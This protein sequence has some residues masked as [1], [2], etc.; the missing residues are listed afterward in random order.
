MYPSATYLYE[1][2]FVVFQEDR[3]P[4]KVCT[5]LL[6]HN[7]HQCHVL[8]QFI[9]NKKWQDTIFPSFFQGI[10]CVILRKSCSI[11]ISIFKGYD[12]PK[13]E[14]LCSTL[15]FGHMN[16]LCSLYQCCLIMAGA[17]FSKLFFYLSL[18]S[19]KRRKLF[20]MMKTNLIGKFSGHAQHI[21][22]LKMVIIIMKLII[23]NNTDRMSGIH[24]LQ[25]ALSYYTKN[26]AL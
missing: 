23:D 1:Y 12:Q 2:L 20:N 26:F 9:S 24:G 5:V 17:V 11:E 16:P 7:Y 18:L 14:K 8:L 3:I 19:L 13:K 4:E 25:I 15:L 21:S 10:N 22:Y 6:L